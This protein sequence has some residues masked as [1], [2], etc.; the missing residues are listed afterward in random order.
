LEDDT[1]RLLWQ[2]FAWFAPCAIAAVLVAAV[3]A[4]WP[5]M[6]IAIALG[7]LGA[8]GTRRLVLGADGV[9]VERRFAKRYVPYR[10]IARVESRTTVFGSRW[11]A[12]RLTNGRRISLGRIG[13]QRAALVQALL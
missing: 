2:S 12:L 9:V 11:L 8:R 10:D 5:S 3:P 4:A 7:W 13:E 1:M 6:P